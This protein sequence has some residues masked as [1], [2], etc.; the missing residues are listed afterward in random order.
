LLIATGAL[1]ALNM[2]FFLGVRTGEQQPS[3]T[4]CAQV[5][6]VSI[7]NM[8]FVECVLDMR[9]V[10]AIA[11]DHHSAMELSK[12]MELGACQ[13]VSVSHPNPETLAP[14]DKCDPDKAWVP[15]NPPPDR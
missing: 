2:M 8:H 14:G 6:E 7:P 9:F 3:P 1:V 15:D 12:F 10:S 11:L 5:T 4:T 13:G